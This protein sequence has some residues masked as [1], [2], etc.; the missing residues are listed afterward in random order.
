M[1]LFVLDIQFPLKDKWFSW[2]TW[3]VAWW[4]YVWRHLLQSL[5]WH[6]MYGC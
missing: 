1:T 2:L 6:H 3:V 4:S 5:E